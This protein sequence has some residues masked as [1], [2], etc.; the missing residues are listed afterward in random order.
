MRL[1]STNPVYSKLNKMSAYAGTYA[2]ATYQGVAGKTLYYMLLVFV[3]AF[4]GIILLEK[5]PTFLAGLLIASI[6]VAF[7]SSLV[8][9]ISPTSTKIAG[10]IYCLFEGILVGVISYI[11]E[12]IIPGV[13][14]IAI[15]GTLAVVIVAATLYLTGLVKVNGK[16]V[17]F[18]LLVS[19]SVFV[20]YFLSFIIS[21][22]SSTFREALASPGI[23][24][25]V[26]LIMIF[27]AS[28]YI[29]FDLENIRQ[30]VE[31]GQPKSLEWFAA[32]GL[33]FT[34]IWLYMEVLPLVAQLLASADN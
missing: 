4:A 15:L 29:M 33:A 32:F 30:V 19:I 12:A 10:T 20:T 18:L 24:I 11:F 1:R 27:I 3:G 34:V 25:L 26:S 23:N 21:F 14:P 6:I 2:Q 22:F 8:A 9:F 5:N 16:F 13:V 17:R 7:I 28:L 31:G